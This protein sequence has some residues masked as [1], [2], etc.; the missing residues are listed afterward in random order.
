MGNL[1]TLADLIPAK[2]GMTCSVFYRQHYSANIMNLVV[3]GK[4]PLD[5]LEQW[6]RADFSD[7]PNHHIERSRYPQPLLKP[8]D[9]P[10]LL[11]VQALKETRELELTFPIPSTRAAVRH[12]TGQLYC[13]SAG[14]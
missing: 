10:R 2:S 1:K 3:Y 13:Q 4:Q 8:E 6:V 5:R 12:Q 11:K 14:P 7:I 9:L